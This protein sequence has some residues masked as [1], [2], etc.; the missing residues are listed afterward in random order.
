MY[1]SFVL[2]VILNGY[3]G[4]SYEVINTINTYFNIQTLNPIHFCLLFTGF[5]II[6]INL[7]LVRD[8]YFRNR[9]TDIKNLY[10]KLLVF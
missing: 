5:I 9:L 1:N 8:N 10:N 2:P 7:V 4:V 3:D 6:I